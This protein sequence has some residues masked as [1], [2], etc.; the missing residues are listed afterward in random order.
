MDEYYRAIRA[1]PLGLHRRWHSCPYKR[2]C[3]YRSCGCVQTVRS[4]LPCKD[5]NALLLHCRAVLQY[6]LQCDWTRCK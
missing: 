4:H 5:G 3:A 1:L 6:W 2:Q